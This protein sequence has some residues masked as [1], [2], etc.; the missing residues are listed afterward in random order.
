MSIKS[1]I[2]AVLETI[3][4]VVI[5][6]VLIMFIFKGITAAYEFGYKVFADEPVSLNNGRTITVGVSENAS[7]KDVA[8]MLEEKGLINDAKLFVVQELLS[9]YHNEIKPGIYDLRTD[10][11]AH[12]MLQI[13]ASGENVVDYGVEDAVAPADNSSEG[14]SYD[15]DE[16]AEE[17]FEDG[18]YIDGEFVPNDELSDN[19]DETQTEE[20][21]GGQE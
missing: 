16:P 7:T 5:F 8:Q 12:D 20:T 19:A 14:S 18:M 6:A 1:L 21:E 2:L 10:M 11:T 15:S 9:A 13:M 3:I 17:Q 4:K